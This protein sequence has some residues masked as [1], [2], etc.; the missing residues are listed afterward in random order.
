MVCCVFVL[1]V[2]FLCCLIVLFL[3]SSSFPRNL[4]YVISKSM[5]PVSHYTSISFLVE[6]VRSEPILL[7]VKLGLLFFIYT[8]PFISTK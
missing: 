1:F 6:I 4:E 8:T 2:F 7:Y 3:I 5:F